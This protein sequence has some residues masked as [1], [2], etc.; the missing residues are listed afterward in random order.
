MGEISQTEKARYSMIW[1][2][3]VRKNHTPRSRVLWCLGTGEVLLK[4]Q[5]LICKM[6]AFQS[7][8]VLKWQSTRLVSARP[9]V[10]TR[11]CKK[12]SSRNPVYNVVTRSNTSCLKH[13][14]IYN[15]KCSLPPNFLKY[16]RWRLVIHLMVV[17]T[18]QSICSDHYAAHSKHTQCLSVKRKTGTGHSGL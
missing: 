10:Q 9:W 4:V 13:A 3:R 14:M 5:I 17:M 8:G 15:L 12:I 6:K 16:V 1:P 11:N 2:M 18:S 7:R